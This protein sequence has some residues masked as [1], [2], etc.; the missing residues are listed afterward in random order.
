MDNSR[1]FRLDAVFPAHCRDRATDS[2]STYNVTA[3]TRRSHSAS[4]H[5]R[6]PPGS[7]QPARCLRVCSSLR[8]WM[9]D[10]FDLALRAYL[11]EMPCVVRIARQLSCARFFSPSTGEQIARVIGASKLS[12][13][14][15]YIVSLYIVAAPSTVWNCLCE[16]VN[17]FSSRRRVRAFAYFRGV[18]A[19][20]SPYIYVLTLR[21]LRSRQLPR[22]L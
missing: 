21:P 17:H 18:D 3:E 5:R 8:G 20:T 15:A 19:L 12:G 9:F 13:R 6:A 4:C 7:R 11:S 22:Y 1:G 2:A 16:R 14:R 10:V